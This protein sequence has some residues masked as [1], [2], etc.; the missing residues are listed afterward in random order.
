MEYRLPILRFN[1]VARGYYQPIYPVFVIDDNPITRQFTLTL[2]EVLRLVP[3]ADVSPLTRAYAERVVRQRVHQPA[4][5]ARVL[6]AY[7]RQCSV[8][9]LRHPQLLDAAHIIE[10]TADQGEPVVPNGLSLCKI[11]HAAFDQRFL[12]ISPDMVVHINDRLLR[13]ED[14]PMLRHGL[15]EMHGR[16]LHGPSR[17]ADRPDPDRLRQRFE[18]FLAG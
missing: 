10:D 16:A 3:G 1:K 14:G 11:H 4:F 13:E 6:L 9:R 5:R 2:D 7:E 18:S 17:R 8:C 15:Q 12:G